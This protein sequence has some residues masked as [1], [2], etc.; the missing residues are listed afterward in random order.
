[1]S[2]GKFKLKIYEKEICE[3]YIMGESPISI[4][5]KYDCAYSSLYRLLKRNNVL[6]KGISISKRKYAIDDSLFEN[7]NTPE[8][9][10]WLGFLYA[11]GYNS[12]KGVCLTLNPKDEEIL[13]KLRLFLKTTKPLRYEKRKTGEVY[14]KFVIENKKISE[15]LTKL[16]C[17]QAKTHKLTYPSF[18]PMNLNRHFIRGYFDG[19]G[20]IQKC[21]W[22]ITSTFDFLKSIETI[23]SNDL[24]FSKGFYY[25]Q[26]HPDRGNNIYTFIQC[27]YNNLILIYNY[28]Y[29]DSDIYLSRK[30]EKFLSIMNSFT[31]KPKFNF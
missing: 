11:D 29:V 20:C 24:R 9:A 5:K 30:R 25:N 4:I 16:G 12:P 18:L 7:I 10:Y 31:T 13:N 17:I 8:K 21:G 27:G 19:D 23:M 22:S 3:L 26:R 6:A 28:L 1:M 14:V 2:N 15:D